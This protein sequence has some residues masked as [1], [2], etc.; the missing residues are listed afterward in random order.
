MPANMEVLHKIIVDGDPKILVRVAEDQAQKLARQVETSTSQQEKTF[1]TQIRAIFDEVQ[2]IEALR[3]TSRDEEAWRRMCLLKARMAYRGKRAKG[4]FEKFVG[5][6]LIPSLELV[7]KEGKEQAWKRFP[8]F[9]EF[10]E[11]ILAYYVA[12]KRG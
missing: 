2:Q 1:T 8:R 12:E 11:A 5:E 10:L 7:T 3:H 4:G 6:V 9:A